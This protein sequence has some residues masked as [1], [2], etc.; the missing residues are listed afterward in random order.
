[1]DVTDESGRRR[2]DDPDDL[3]RIEIETALNAGGLDVVPVLANGART[4]RAE[5][6]PASLHPLLR[7][8]AAIIRRDP[9]FH[10][11]VARLSTALRASVK[12]GILDLASLGGERNASS[13]GKLPRAGLPGW[14]LPAGAIGAATLA[15][16]VWEPW[17]NG[18]GFQSQPSASSEAPDHANTLI[19]SWR[20]PRFGCVTTFGTDR[21]M[22]RC[23]GFGGED[24][25]RA[26]FRYI[27]GGQDVEMTFPNS[28]RIDTLHF[29][30]RN[31]I[32]TAADYFAPPE[33]GITLTRCGDVGLPSCSAKHRRSQASN[34]GE[35][36]SKPTP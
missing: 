23:S 6:L 20:E 1:V 24:A 15:L 7:R 30:D 4:P 5:E 9:D 21:V 19:G 14:M 22:T 18:A 35:D 26:N 25:T 31:T 2:L 11:D 16:F 8:N 13:A 27:N 28:D 29:V 3:V 10:D 36:T 32:T 12:T 34:N 33:G 17:R